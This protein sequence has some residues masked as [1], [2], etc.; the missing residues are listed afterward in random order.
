MIREGTLLTTRDGAIIYLLLRPALNAASTWFVLRRAG[1]GI[2]ITDFTVYY[3]SSL[4]ILGE[5]C[6]E[7]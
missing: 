3:L 5:L 4:K 1:T 2:S 7:D 6:G